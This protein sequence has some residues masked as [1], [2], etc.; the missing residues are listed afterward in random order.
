MLT[1]AIKKIFGKK[2][3]SPTELTVLFGGHSGNSEFIAKESFKYFKQNGINARLADMSKYNFDRLPEENFLLVVVSTHGEGEPPSEARKFYRRLFAN[4]TPD[5]KKLRF[6]VCALGDS[7]Y[8]KFCQ[9]GKEID[10]RLEE[11]GAS[12]FLE[13]VDCDVEFNQTAAQWVST[14]LGKYRSGKPKNTAANIQRNNNKEYFGATVKNRYALDKTA[15]PLVYH[16]VLTVDDKNFN[17]LPGDSV[18]IVPQNPAALVSALIEKLGSTPEN[19]VTYKDKNYTLE[20]LLTK[21]IEITTISKRL[22]ERYLKI[23]K[24]PE[25]K[26]LLSDE[27]KFRNYLETSDAIDLLTDFPWKGNL[28]ELSEIFRPIQPRL[29]SVASSIKS[30][31]DELHLMVK[32]ICLQVH[33]RTR[34]GACSS[35][36]NQWIKP[37]TRIKLKVIPNKAFRLPKSNQPIIMIGAGTGIAPFRAFMQELVAENQNNPAW[38]IFGEKHAHR[39]FFYQEEWQDLFDKSTLTRFD[40]AF[41][42]DSAKKIYVQHQLEKHA[43]LFYEWL[44]SGAHV[45]VCGSVKM[46]HDVRKAAISSLSE[47]LQPGAKAVAYIEKLEE[48]D[49]WHEDLY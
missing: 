33:E 37:G 16:L 27:K 21:R 10:Q 49:R 43:I 5:L 40:V 12:R 24:N 7:S 32:L 45:Y 4:D 35:Y 3:L 30:N 17:Y 15:E 26:K 47:V 20:E 22:L 13:R 28:D 42:R 11:L 25:L 14:F 44:E 8:E 36:L 9:T 1:T 39:D 6:S 31:P 38:L 18:S 19:Q 34:L 41:S 46:G 23:S 48:D 29:Y 2:K